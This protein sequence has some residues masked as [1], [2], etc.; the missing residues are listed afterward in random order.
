MTKGLV[1]V[2]V[3]VAAG[4]TPSAP[5]CPPCPSAVAA[6]APASRELPPA[7][8]LGRA[9]SEGDAGAC[10][11]LSA[12]HRL[13]VGA[14]QDEVRA[15]EYAKRALEIR[16]GA[17]ARGD[18]AACDDIPDGVTPLALNPASPPAGPPV[19]DSAVVLV[20]LMKDGRALI[21]GAPVQDFA[22]AVRPACEKGARAVVNADRD[23]P[24]GVVIR[25]VDALKQAGCTRIA[26]GVAAPK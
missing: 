11:K 24:H 22:T 16:L 6:S 17:C 14:S 12:M 9:C 8:T 13:G 25:T 20:T 4:C 26:F 19:F 23:A 21:D 10:E 18:E 5:S 7:E 1:M 2:T 15:R 3:V